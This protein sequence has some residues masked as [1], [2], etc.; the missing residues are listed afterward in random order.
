[1]NPDEARRE[2]DKL[3]KEINYHNHR[4]YV[5]AAPVISDA[6]YDALMQEL[7]ELE[8][9]FPDLVTPDS[10][11]QRVGGEPLEGFEQVTHEVRMMSLDNTY[12]TEDLMEFDRRVQEAVG[13]QAY[14]VQQKIDGVAVSLRYQDGVLVQGATRGDGQT[15]DDVTANLRTIASI[16]LRLLDGAFSKGAL[17][18]R[19]EVYMPKRSFE[20]INAERKTQGLDQFAN[21][22]NSAAGSLKLLDSREVAKRGL[23]FKMHSP[24]RPKDWD[25]DSF[26]DFMIA[27]QQAGLPIIPGMRR[28]KYIKE[29]LAYIENWEGKRHNLAYAVDGVVIKVDS[30]VAQAELGHTAKSPRWSVAFKYP[31]EQTTTRL[32]DIGLNVSRT[33][34]VNPVAI[35]EP[36]FISGT[37]VSRAGLFNEAEIRRKNLKIGDWVLVEKGGEI[38]PQVIR[39]IPERRDGS[40]REFKMPEH[41][42]VCGSKLEKYQDDAA[43]RCINRDCSA[44]LRASLALYASRGAADIEGMGYKLIVQLVDKGLVK[45]I[46]DIYD[47]TR[48][49]LIE[50]E[51]MGERSADNLLTGIETSKTRP[52]DRILFGL[53]IRFV[54]ST[55]AR[56]LVEKF[57]DIDELMTASLEELSEIE[58]I[59]PVTAQSVIDFFANSRNLELI[60]RLRKAG[61]RLACEE[62]K[63]VEK[64]LAGL[65]F[66]FTGGLEN[67]SRDEAG[68]E[69]LKRGAKV[70]SSVSKKTSYVVA[71]SNPGSKYEKAKSLGVKVISEE[72]FCR[73]LEGK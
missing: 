8:S 71:G 56:A 1:M 52:F 7:I 34:A 30:F 38:I 41:C 54:G 9:Q 23:A 5:L 31:P 6:E 24:L 43:Y 62:I 66:V 59:G 16:P 37:T 68:Q 39:S 21:P 14:V 4:Y 60:K 18:V 53:G 32:L 51:R 36:V 49:Q 17:I 22:R 29:A 63:A 58:G 48:E 57:V 61:V 67:M 55:G 47:L 15:G 72:E 26:H 11:T 40:E 28:C 73:L 19:G 44:I 25:R 2:I 64:N 46:A 20:Q 69:A 10:P 50:L 12:S 70:S 13:E 42:P 35:L 27:L 45:S 3:R 65:T 33:G